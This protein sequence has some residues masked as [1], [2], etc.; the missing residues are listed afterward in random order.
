M[1][2]DVGAT[3]G[4]TQTLGVGLGVIKISEWTVGL[5]LGIGLLISITT[6]FY[7]VSPE[8]DSNSVSGEGKLITG[9]SR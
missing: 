2:S 4:E 3:T 8:F 6:P 5:G 1:F 9:F 7:N